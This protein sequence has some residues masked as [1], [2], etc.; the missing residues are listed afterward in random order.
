MKQVTACTDFQTGFYISIRWKTNKWIHFLSD[1]K[2]LVEEKHL[3]QSRSSINLLR[4]TKWKTVFYLHQ[5]YSLTQ[6]RKCKP[7]DREYTLHGHTVQF[8]QYTVCT[9]SSDPRQNEHIENI[10]N[11]AKTT[12]G[13]LESLVYWLVHRTSNTEFPCSIPAP[14]RKFQGLNFLLSL[15]NICEHGLQ[16]TMIVRLKATING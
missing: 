5:C 1:R 11:K 3:K 10:C 15:K 9:N 4:G 14:N 2:Q 7:I 16:E 13:F 8:V 12:I 6:S